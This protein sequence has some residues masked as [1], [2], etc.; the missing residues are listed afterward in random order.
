MIYGLYLSAQGAHA[1]TVRLNVLANN[2][3]NTSTGW[4]KRDLA[5]FQSHPTFDV[6]NGT[7]EELPRNLNESTGGLSLAEIATN[8]SDGPVTQA[9]GTFDVALNGPGFLRVSDGQDT[10]L[11]RNGCFSLND[12]NQLVAQDTGF[13]VLGL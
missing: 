6:E 3:A 2:I 9:G 7:A 10:F 12:Q 8:F 13:A 11:T 5:I 4:F 1:Q